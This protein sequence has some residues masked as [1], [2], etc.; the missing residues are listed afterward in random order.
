M[1]AVSSF[2]FRVSSL[3]RSPHQ[4]SRAG[5]VKLEA[6]PGLPIASCALPGIVRPH[7]KR[8]CGA[9]L[10]AVAPGRDN[11]ART[12]QKNIFLPGVFFCRWFDTVWKRLL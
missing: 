6:R 7:H 12:V 2:E 11:A 1:M 10:P 8:V 4:A 9:T 5:T 3:K